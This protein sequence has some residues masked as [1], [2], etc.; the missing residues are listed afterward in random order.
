MAAILEALQA[1]EK[2]SFERTPSMSKEEQT[3]TLSQPQP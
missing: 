1:L 2:K 3:I